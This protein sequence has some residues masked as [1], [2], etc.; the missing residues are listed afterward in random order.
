[1]K[2][3]SRTRVREQTNYQKIKT[4]F[5]RRLHSEFAADEN[6]SPGATKDLWVCQVLVTRISL[7]F[8]GEAQKQE[9]LTYYHLLSSLRGTLLAVE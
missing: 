7:S 3:Y 2:I 4:C 8:S 1:M 6:K 5:L 9:Y